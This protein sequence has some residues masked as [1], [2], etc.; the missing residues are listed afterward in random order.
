MTV[1][2]PRGSTRA[3]WLGLV[4]ACSV[5]TPSPEETVR[6]FYRALEAGDTRAVSELLSAESRHALGDKLSL[7]VRE[8]KDEI[9]DG[10]GVKALEI[11]AVR[12]DGHTATVEVRTVLRNGDTDTETISLVREDGAWRIQINK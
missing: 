5:I 1:R 3:A 2:P 4:V 10:G 8:T 9:A 12:T 6:R 7:I 11:L